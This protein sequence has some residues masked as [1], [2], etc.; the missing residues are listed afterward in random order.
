MGIAD[1]IQGRAE[2]TEAKGAIFIRF[3]QTAPAKQTCTSEGAEYGKFG[4][5]HA[6]TAKL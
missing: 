1:E 6:L 2:E 5:D 3:N 4:I